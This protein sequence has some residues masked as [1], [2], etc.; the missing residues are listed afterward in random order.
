MNG[1]DADIV[2][3]AQNRCK[4]ALI[5]QMIRVQHKTEQTERIIRKSIQ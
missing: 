4:R 1:M 5:R 2:H 3:D